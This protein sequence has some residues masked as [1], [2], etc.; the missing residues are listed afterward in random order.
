MASRCLPSRPAASEPESAEPLEVPPLLRQLDV[1]RR[2]EEEEARELALHG[3][4]GGPGPSQRWAAAQR[5]ATRS[6]RPA[7]AALRWHGTCMKLKRALPALAETAAP[8]ALPHPAP[9]GPVVSRATVIVEEFGAGGSG[10]GN[11]GKGAGASGDGAQQAAGGPGAAGAAGSSA[12]SRLRTWANDHGAGK[13]GERLGALREAVAAAPPGER[14]SSLRGLFKRGLT[15]ASSGSSGSL[16]GGGAAGAAAGVTRSESWEEVPRGGGEA[17]GGGP[18]S[19]A[20]SRVSSFTA[21]L[22]QRLHSFAANLSSPERGGPRAAPPGQQGEVPGGPHGVSG[23]TGGSGGGSEARDLA[24]GQ[25]VL[26][27][28]MRWKVG[29]ARQPLPAD[30]SSDEEEGGAPGPASEHPAAA[31][32]PAQ[33]APSAAANPGSA[34]DAAVAG[35]SEAGSPRQAAAAVASPHQQ[36]LEAQR[37]RMLAERAASPPHQRPLAAA[38]PAAPAAGSP[39]TEPIGGSLP[40]QQG[41]QPWGPGLRDRLQPGRVFAA[42]GEAVNAVAVAEGGGTAAAFCVGHA[43]SIKLYDLRTGDQASVLPAARCALCAA[44]WGWGRCCLGEPPG[45]GYFQMLSRHCAA[46]APAAHT[47]ALSMLPPAAALNQRLLPAA[48][49]PGPAPR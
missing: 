5:G 16:L 11:D 33:A 6:R 19:P 31:A 4:A 38:A 25:D 24:A 18:A 27:G 49:Q 47:A 34:A 17:A 30:D 2:R 45:C 26:A 35:S 39:A 46:P 9:A 36:L 41:V 3:E 20:G 8:A 1:V 23:S 44:R 15:G 40:Q 22:S 10:N 7:A 21:S 42:G 37:Q 32:W 48:D 43:G 14:A 13:L 29:S 28:L 12:Y